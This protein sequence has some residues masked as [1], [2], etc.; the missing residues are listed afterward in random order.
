MLGLQEWTI[1]IQKTIQKMKLHLPE[2]TG[3]I[4]LS[5]GLFPKLYYPEITYIETSGYKLGKLAFERM[6]ECLIGNTD[7]KELFI[8]SRF[9]AGGSL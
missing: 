5:D 4:A 9:V 6:M 3:V 7:S 8:T 2:D 1:T